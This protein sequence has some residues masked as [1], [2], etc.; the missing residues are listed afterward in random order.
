[1][2]PVTDKTIERQL[3]DTFFYQPSTSTTTICVITLDSGM[4]YVGTSSSLTRE[5]FD[6]ELGKKH[7]YDNAVDKAIE[8]EVHHALANHYAKTG[9]SVK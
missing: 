2:N 3:R 6:P 7:A 5:T 1:M 4:A 9:V 8:G